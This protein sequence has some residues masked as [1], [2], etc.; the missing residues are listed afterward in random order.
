MKSEIILAFWED[1]QENPPDMGY[2]KEIVE[3]LVEEIIRLK[4]KYE[5]LMLPD[6]GIENVENA[7]HD[8]CTHCGEPLMCGQDGL[9]FCFGCGS[10]GTPDSGGTI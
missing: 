8:M 9:P 7:N 5:S 6:I 4:I 3:P 1:M 10:K 2:A